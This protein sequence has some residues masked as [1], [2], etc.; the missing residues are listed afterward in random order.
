MSGVG[1]GCIGSTDP[2]CG[3]GGGDPVV[4]V[5]KDAVPGWTP[6]VADGLVY[7]GQP[8]LGPSPYTAAEA[9]TAPI[10]KRCDDVDGMLSWH[11][12]PTAVVC[13]CKPG[14]EGWRRHESVGSICREVRA[15]GDVPG[16]TPATYRGEPVVGTVARSS[17]LE[18]EPLVTDLGG[19]KL[20]CEDPLSSVFLDHAG[21]AHCGCSFRG[22]RDDDGH[23]RCV[24]PP[25]SPGRWNCIVLP[26][27]TPASLIAP[28]IVVAVTLIFVG[29]VG[30]S[31]LRVVEPSPADTVR[32][33]VREPGR[34][35]PFDVVLVPPLMTGLMFAMTDDWVSGPSPPQ[36]LFGV[37]VT[38]GLAI[39][40][41]RSRLVGLLVE[42][43]G[44]GFLWWGTA[45][46]TRFATL[47][48]VGVLFALPR[49]GRLRLRR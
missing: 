13:V 30:A 35:W 9:A 3:I 10:D 44:L 7:R 15:R 34:R 19:Q 4:V 24:E 26:E 6:D 48:A 45:G 14:Y 8:Y 49:L 27:T 28:A 1:L 38:R 42:L 23:S 18:K 20:R 41:V 22:V 12:T 31:K 32:V 16:W 46:P 25:P 47:L 37:L 29:A 33:A 17:L 39:H 5:P 11:L 40:A 21:V 2:L 43:G 36:F